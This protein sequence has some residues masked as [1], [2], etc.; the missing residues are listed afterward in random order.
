MRNSYL[1]ATSCLAL[2]M[3]QACASPKTRVETE[4]VRDYIV[5]AELPE[6][7]QIRY[8][9]IQRPDLTPINEQF[10]LINVRDRHYMLEFRRRCF[11]LYDNTR[12]TPDVRREGNILR[13]RFDTV[14]GCVIDRIY[15][16]DEAQAL[17]LEQLGDAPGRE[18]MTVDPSNSSPP[19][20]GSWPDLG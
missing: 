12:I 14:R 15:Q 19:R 6:A 4:A 8:G 3:L 17:E 11:A 1:I 20:R 13:A 7:D 5:A 16:I 9:P 2:I 18:V 10:A